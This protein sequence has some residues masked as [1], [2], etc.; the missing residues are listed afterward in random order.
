MDNAFKTASYPGYT[1][2]EL[3]N[4]VSEGNIGTEFNP[5]AKNKIREEIARREKA[6]LGDTS[7]MTHGERLRFARTGK[8]R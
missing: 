3:R 7:V 8:A 1:T 5:E 4:M 6:A 2:N